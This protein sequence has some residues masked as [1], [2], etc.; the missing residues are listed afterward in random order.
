MKPNYK[1]FTRVVL[2]QRG[3]NKYFYC[4]NSIKHPKCK[5]KTTLNKSKNNLYSDNNL[6]QT[7]RYLCKNPDQS[8]SHMKVKIP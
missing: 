2:L 5:Y 4:V 7:A 6:S 8:V 3:T 1:P